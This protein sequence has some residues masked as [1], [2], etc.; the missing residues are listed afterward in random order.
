MTTLV[1]MST[2]RE[3]TGRERSDAVARELQ[4]VFGLSWIKVNQRGMVNMPVDVWD[5]LLMGV[6]PVATDSPPTQNWSIRR[7]NERPNVPVA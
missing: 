1:P 5:R 3:F 6:T 7:P 2:L 4:R